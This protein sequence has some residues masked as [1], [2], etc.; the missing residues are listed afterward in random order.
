VTG[1]YPGSRCP[2]QPHGPSPAVQR[3][4]GTQGAQQA[5]GKALRSSTQIHGHLPQP[6]GRFGCTRK[7]KNQ[8]G[9]S[10]KENIPAREILEG[11]DDKKWF[12][13][14]LRT[15]RTHK[16]WGGRNEKNP[17]RMAI[18]P[19]RVR[20]GRRHRRARGRRRCGSC[21]G[22]RRRSSLATAGD[23]RGLSSRKGSRHVG[24]G[25]QGGGVEMWAGEGEG[26]TGGGGWPGGG[27]VRCEGGGDVAESCCLAFYSNFRECISEQNKMFRF[28]VVSNSLVKSRKSNK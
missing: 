8:A 15:S 13:C 21:T 23:G 19:P 7:L 25:G 14:L 3:N 26:G 1:G 24:G 17:M 10:F 22:T 28:E 16:S 27:G 20:P 12:G 9:A 6:C 11:G 5:P 2:P 18:P 4:H